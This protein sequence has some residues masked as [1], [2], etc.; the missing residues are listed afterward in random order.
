[1]GFSPCIFTVL[2]FTLFCPQDYLFL[3]P[4]YTPPFSQLTHTVCITFSRPHGGLVTGLVISPTGHRLYSCSNTGSLALFSLQDSQTPKLL[5]LLGNIVAKGD[6]GNGDSHVPRTLALS[7]DGS[8]L[9]LI[10]PF[11]FTITVLD[12]ES[13]NELL[14]LDITPVTP[15]SNEAKSFMDTAKLVCFSPK[16]L[17]ELLVITKESRLL[18]FCASSGQLLSEVPH[19]HRGQCSCVLVSG[20]GRYLVTAGDQVLKVWDYSM[21]MDLN[22]QVHGTA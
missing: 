13:L 15:S 8:R 9:A 14:R 10:G 4:P 16:L 20:D 11:N 6:D 19:L 3:L 1:M 18:K 2:H 21:S 12:A 17:N 22:F 7:H 5:R